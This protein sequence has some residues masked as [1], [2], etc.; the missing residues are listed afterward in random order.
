MASKRLEIFNSL[1]IE[2]DAS[3]HASQGKFASAFL[4]RD[5][6]RFIDKYSDDHAV[7]PIL[8]GLSAFLEHQ[9]GVPN[10]TLHSF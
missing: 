5:L 9:K 2:H 7:R 10:G 8:K 1:L 3:S 6:S 4:K